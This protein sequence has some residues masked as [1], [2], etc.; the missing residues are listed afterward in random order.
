VDT[1]IKGFAAGGFDTRQAVGEDS[2]QI[3][4][5]AAPGFRNDAAPSFREITAP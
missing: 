1:L 2:L 4:R 3:P 5:H